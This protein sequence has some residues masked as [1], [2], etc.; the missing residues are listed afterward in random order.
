MTRIFVLARRPVGLPT[1]DDFDEISKND[2]ALGDGDVRVEPMV[3]SVDPYLRGRMS[4]ARSYVAPFEVGGA[5]SSAG[6]GKVLESHVDGYR[7]GDLVRGEFPWATSLVAQAST[8]WKLPVDQDVPPSAYLGA[9]GMTGLTAYVGLV[10]LGQ[11]TSDDEVFVTG[12]AGAVGSVVGQLARISGARVV[13]S[14]G[15]ATKVEQLAKLGFTAGIDYRSSDDFAQTL[16][17]AFPNGISLFFDNVGGSQLEAAIHQMKDFGRAVLC[18]AISQYNDTQLPSGPRGFEGF[19]VRRR[20]RVQGFIV[21]DHLALYREYLSL[22][23]QWVRSGQLQTLETIVE[24][25]DSLP[26]AFLSLFTGGN[27]GKMLVR[28]AI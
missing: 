5:I 2:E 28:V 14:A 16:R 1:I 22:A 7:V 13:G 11:V 10:V 17:A 9:L 21:S 18:G 25:F 6:I 24:G 12:A 26:S 20:L 15:G 27:V 19:V 4:D 8:L 23:S 3:L